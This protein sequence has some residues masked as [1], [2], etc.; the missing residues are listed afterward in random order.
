M[1]NQTVTL[2]IP[3]EWIIGLPEEELTYRQ[4]IRLG[5]RQYKLGRAIELY[6]EGVGSLGYIAEQIG[7]PKQELIQVMRS[8][9]IEPE[10]S[11]D[12]IRE[13]LSV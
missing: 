3:R 6:R 11:E 1:I 8:E 2:E 7:L 9:G 10:F 4:I 12:T 5:I 13:E